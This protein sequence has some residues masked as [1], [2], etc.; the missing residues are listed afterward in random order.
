M[1]AWDVT[2]P[3]LW[4]MASS[5]KPSD[6]S[7]VCR[8]A[9]LSPDWP[10]AGR[11]DREARRDERRSGR[12]RGRWRPE[13]PSWA[14][15]WWV[16]SSSWAE[17]SSWSSTSSWWS[18]RWW[19]SGPRSWWWCARPSCWGVCRRAWWLASPVPLHADSST[20][21]AMAVAALIEVRCRMRVRSLVGRTKPLGL[22]ASTLPCHRGDHQGA[23]QSGR[24]GGLDI[25]PWPIRPGLVRRCRGGRTASS[26]RST[27]A[28][29]PTRTVTASAISRASGATS[30]TSPGSGVDA[31][32]LSPIYPSPMADF[33]YD[34]A[35]YEDIDPVFGDLGQLRPA[36]RRAP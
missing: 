3:Y 19:S 10:G 17:P 20:S 11:R 15:P 35:D 12:R 25:D 9:T 1:T 7:R 4:S 6:S 29:S 26:T 34:V 16:A 21:P 24:V 31:V 5:Q 32:W 23:G 14:G 30:T 28:R 2:V 27:R 33:G 8:A 22:A 18:P 36:A 13:R